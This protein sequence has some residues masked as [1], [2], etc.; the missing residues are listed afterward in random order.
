MNVTEIK[1]GEAQQ[2]ETQNKQQDDRFQAL[3]TRFETAH[4]F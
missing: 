1:T 3:K 2:E 4:C